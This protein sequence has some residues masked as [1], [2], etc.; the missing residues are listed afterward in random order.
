MAWQLSLVGFSLASAQEVS[1]GEST[2][3]AATTTT[4]TRVAQ[5]LELSP[6]QAQSNLP[7]CI[8]GIVTCYD[9]GM[10]LFVQDETG[11]V[12]V[13]YTGD[14]LHLRPG[15]YVE[16]TGVAKPGRYSPIIEPQQ[17]RP[18]EA[19]LS[20]TP[21]RVSL[22][23]IYLEGLDAQWVE[24]DGV[25]RSQEIS[26]N[27]LNLE[28][29]ESPY[30]VS[31]WIPDYQ[32]YE[33]LNL[34]GSSVRVRGV[35]GASMSDRGQ[36]TKFQVF[37]STL[38]DITIQRSAPADLFS[39]PPSLIRDLATYR[40]RKGME[41]IARAQGIVTLH[42]PG[43]ALFIQDSTGGLK[44]QSKQLVEGL[45]PGT[46]VEVAGFLGP[47][48]EA[49]LLEDA[50][51]RKGQT[52]T[53]TQPA[54]LSS[55]N[56]FSGHH[57]N[58]LVEIE[59]YFLGQAYSPSNCL[60]LLLQAGDRVVTA[61]LDATSLQGPLTAPEA[62]SRLSVTGVCRCEA[63]FGGDPKVCLLLRSPLDVQVISR[64]SLMRTLGMR[65]LAAAAVLTSAGL[66]VA[67]W[68]IQRQRRRTEH[69]LQLQ[70]SLQAEMRQGEE[71]LRRSLEE[72]ERIGRDLHDDIIQSIYAA[73]LS[74]EDCRRVVRQSP[75]QAESRLA[76]AVHTLNNAIGSVRSFIAGL[77]PKVLDGREF[78]TALKS[79]ALT[80]GDG[81][82]QFEIEVDPAGANRLSSAQATQLLH[83]AK[84]AMSNSLR[85]AHASRVTV[86]LRRIGTVV[87][88]EIRDDGSGFN[89]SAVGSTGQGLRN[90]A[91]RARD[92][93]ADL[94]II[95][96][97]GQGCHILATVPQRD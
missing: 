10:V 7:V 62:G 85:H 83:I 9:P 12:F 71:R 35:V 96:A 32:G 42:W 59:G 60:A 13:Y 52:N 65:V 86:R 18:L 90:M 2:P 58:Q 45:A 84:E 51:I 78:K 72:R 4:L 36:P 81:P 38:A 6:K 64:P 31:V 34:V 19:G 20:V 88:L 87:H 5:V 91:A 61:L 68:F 15:E 79:L 50:L 82:T 54:Q 80:I 17:I 94:R 33:R 14:R 97:P 24:T 89:P 3:A 28:L 47:V 92:I 37:A 30:R 21:R 56:L 39:G 49:P 93:D 40:A 63:G 74:L 69:V 29:A 8:R 43:R 1:P 48:L 67:L 22:A 76:E 26:N 27:R 11:G 77:E 75:G 73:G 46:V 16:I 95:S 53:L 41:G 23:R 44:V 70:V 55:E 57:D 66:A 25:V